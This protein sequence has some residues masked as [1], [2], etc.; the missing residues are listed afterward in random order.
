MEN[1]RLERLQELYNIYD[2]SWKNAQKLSEDP[3][4]PIGVRETYDEIAQK[5]FMKL[6]DVKEKLKKLT[7]N[8]L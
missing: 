7:K 8:V 1:K 5:H 4:L 6:Q 2:S 3:M